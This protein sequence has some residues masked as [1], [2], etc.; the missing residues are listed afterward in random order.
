MSCH[1]AT[2]GEGE[3]TLC[4]SA[5][6]AGKAALSRFPTAISSTCTPA[7]RAASSAR[8]SKGMSLSTLMA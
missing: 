6:K 2:K 5:S 4:I 8:S 7:A 1:N 3:L